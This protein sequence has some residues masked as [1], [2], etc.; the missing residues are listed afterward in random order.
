MTKDLNNQYS[1]SS[2]LMSNDLNEKIKMRV[3]DY[4]VPKGKSKEI[5]LAELKNLITEKETQI[6]GSKKKSNNIILSISAIAAGLLVLI[7]LWQL[8]FVMP[9]SKVAAEMGSQTEYLLPDGTVVHLNADSQITF[10]KRKFRSDRYLVLNGEAFFNVTKGSSFRIETPN[11]EIM[12]LGTSF[13]VYSRDDL[14]K[15][16]CVTGN[17]MVSSKN[18]TV[19]VKANESAEL[20]GGILKAS[21]DDKISYITGWINGDFY[22]ENA[23]LNLVFDEIER[24]FNIK[25]ARRNM[26]KDFFTGSFNNKDLNTALEIVCI[27]MGLKYEIDENGE[28]SVINK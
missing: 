23:P 28:I 10:N 9:Q 24:Q 6:V 26:D 22:F 13:N 5:A 12:V 27:P 18:Q 17:V 4:K 19:S 14:F 21:H 7:G 20:K 3:S 11:G 16:S 25:F 1:E 2:D 8:L 15:V